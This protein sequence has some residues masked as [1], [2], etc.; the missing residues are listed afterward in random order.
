MKLNSF[1]VSVMVML[2]SVAYGARTYKLEMSGV[3]WKSCHTYVRAAF[4]KSFKA[5]S[6]KILPSEKKPRFQTVTFGSEKDNITRKEAEK[7]L[8]DKA[9]RYIVWKLHKVEKE[10]ASKYP[11]HWGDPP[12]IQTRDYRKLPGDYGHGSSTLF[13]WIEKNM[14]EDK[15]KDIKLKDGQ[16]H[17]LLLRN[18]PF[19]YTQT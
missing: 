4:E 6:I 8:G 16:M 14:K 7:A 13:K 19:P 3:T 10:K 11:K 9:K 15:L 12:A 18:T 17:L 5:S 2:A 1:I